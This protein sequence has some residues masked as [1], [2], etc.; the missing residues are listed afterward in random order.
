MTHASPAHPGDP[1]PG[2]P[3]VMHQ[4]WEHLLFLHWRVPAELLQPHLPPG[5]TVDTYDG[6]AWLGV[7]PFWMR[8]VR[9]RFL[10]CVPGLSDFLELNLRTYAT[11][12]A[13]AGVWFFSLDANQKIAVALART[14]FKLP[15]AHAAID[16][17]LAPPP[18]PSPDARFI[19]AP[20]DTGQPA[21][22][23]VTD[24]AHPWIDFTSLRRGAEPA[25][26][27]SF[28]YRARGPV[29]H[30]TPGTLDHFLVER[31]L[32]YA[33]NPKRQRLSHGRVAHT[34]YP[35]H[36]AEFTAGDDTLFALNGLPRV[37][38]PPDHAVYSPGVDV[39]IYPLR[40][41]DRR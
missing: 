36:D 11:G 5:L 39:R 15:Y 35:L 2:L 1:P 16:S 23:T 12:P 9:P 18:T 26:R 33:W 8:R 22:E 27:C 37:K 21:T 34:A 13:G 17:T 3:C 10:P 38:R 7:V 29:R 30:A 25:Q 40:R 6:S 41:A 14:L 19:P 31:Y 24:P 20:P 28:H 4:R 32:L